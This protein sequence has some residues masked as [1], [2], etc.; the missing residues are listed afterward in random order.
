MGSKPGFTAYWASLFTFLGFSFSAHKRRLPGNSQGYCK[1]S[2]RARTGTPPKRVT[3]P[4]ERSITG[5]DMGP[6]DSQALFGSETQHAREVQM[7]GHPPVT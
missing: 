6:D 7:S 1:D 4:L 5:W 3:S 2:R